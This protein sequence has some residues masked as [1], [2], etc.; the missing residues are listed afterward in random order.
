MDTWVLVQ[1]H[2]RSPYQSTTG[3]EGGEGA[4]VAKDSTTVVTSSLR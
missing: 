4:R 1:V 2:A 3:T